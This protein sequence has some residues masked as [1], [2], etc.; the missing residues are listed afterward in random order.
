VYTPAI[1]YTLIFDAADTSDD[2]YVRGISAI[3]GLDIL[4]SAPRLLL[5]EATDSALATLRQIP[6]VRV[7]S[8]H[9]IGIPRPPHQRL[10]N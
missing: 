7:T 9:S 4:D 2:A 5:V 8:E 1:R 6:G 3:P 10:A